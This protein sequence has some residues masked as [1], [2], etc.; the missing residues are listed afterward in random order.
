MGGGI[1]RLAS[2]T[3]LGIGEMGCNV[4]FVTAKYSDE[5]PEFEKLT[6]NVSIYRLPVYKIFGYKR[7]PIVR[8]N[9]K[10]KAAM[11]KLGN[12][13]ID[14]VI[15]L[16]RFHLTSH[17][18]ANFGK[19]KKIPVYLLEC[20]GAPLTLRNRILDIPLRAVERFLSRRIFK[21][22][23]HFFAMSQAARTF[24]REQ[25]GI[26]TKDSLWSCSIRVESNLKK[27]VNPKKIT[28]TYCGRIENLKGEE[29]L[30]K[31][32]MV[33]V[34]EY[35][36][37]HLNFVGTGSY[38]KTLKSSFKHKNITYFG[39]QGIEAINDINNQSDIAVCAT[40]FPDGAVPNSVLE[41]G[42]QKCA[43][44]CSPNG[45][46]VEIINDGIN[47][48]FTDHAVSVDSMVSA[49]RKAIEDRK[50]RETLANNIYTDISNR[51]STPMVSSRIIGDLDL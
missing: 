2:T 8:K 44:V 32:F 41:A 22:V 31:A 18:G 10:F 24:L 5:Q 21:K 45:G 7:F 20:S 40:N 33:L 11:N 36:N 19:S 13:R 1:A 26:E 3:F 4:I 9:H 23:D 38:L 6:D 50:L 51:Y 49:L 47:G 34:S 25:Y 27:K 35:S 29:Q 46:F 15:V 39:Q 12:T 37:L 42:S 28:I 16:T 17:V 48:L 43:M 14:R 30:A